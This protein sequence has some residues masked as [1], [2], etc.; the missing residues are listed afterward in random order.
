[1]HC[2]PGCNWTLD[3]GQ[4][5]QTQLLYPMYSWE[6]AL[7]CEKSGHNIFSF[8][9]TFHQIF[10][11]FKK[12]YFVGFPSRVVS[13]SSTTRLIFALRFSELSGSLP[14]HWGESSLT[15]EV[16]VIQFPKS[17]N[18]AIFFYK[19]NSVRWWTRVCGQGSMNFRT[20]VR[21]S[22]DFANPPPYHQFV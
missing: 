7:H 14:R 13:P 22:T 4:P 20:R 12:Y 17:R 2:C 15:P 3:T 10:F 5:G 19:H 11:T 16:L 21:G 18:G 9:P 6:A 8:N 1:M